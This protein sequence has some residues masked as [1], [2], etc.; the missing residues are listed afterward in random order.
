MINSEIAK[1]SDWLA[2]KLSLN[3]SKSKR[4]IFD[5]KRKENYINDENVNTINVT[6]NGQNL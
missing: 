5:N 3:V 6:L 2:D 1:I 4:L